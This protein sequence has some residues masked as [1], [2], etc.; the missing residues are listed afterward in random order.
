MITEQEMADLIRRIERLEKAVFPPKPGHKAKS[1][2][3]SEDIQG[4]ID[5]SLNE[6]AFA[7]TFL[8][9]KSGPR[10]FALLLAYL[11][12][13][14]A[15]VNVKVKEIRKTWNRMAGKHKLGPYNSKYSNVA[16]D[17]G[18]V[19]P[20]GFGEYKLSKNWKSAL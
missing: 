9:G 1:K 7:K 12:K 17:N 14:K 5:F 8:N 3:E 18:W 11:A 19:D 13:G 20:A 15:N 16:K 2:T 4:D 6:R 10:K